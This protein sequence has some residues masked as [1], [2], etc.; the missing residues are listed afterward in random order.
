MG[1]QSPIGATQRVGRTA[2]GQRSDG[3]CTAIS[4][5]AV[6]IENDLDRERLR[7]VAHGCRLQVNVLSRGALFSRFFFVC[8]LDLTTLLTVS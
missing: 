4:E 2:G 8:F 6:K 1:V 3:G 7:K 5:S